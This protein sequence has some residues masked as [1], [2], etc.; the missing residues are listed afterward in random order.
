MNRLLAGIGAVSLIAAAAFYAGWTQGAASI[1]T[2]WAASRAATQDR[3]DDLG[4]RLDV[5]QTKLINMEGERDALAIE[6]QD[7]AIA[8]PDAGRVALPSRS[9][10]R[11]N[12]Y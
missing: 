10:Q 8:D 6:L 2:E 3:L 9:V 5:A 7:A 11:L 12:R 1:R 4:A